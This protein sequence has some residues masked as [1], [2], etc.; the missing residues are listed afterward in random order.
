M[1][2]KQKS[3]LVVA[4][5]W[6]QDKFFET[7]YVNDINKNG[8]EEV[9]SIVMNNENGKVTLK[10]KTNTENYEFL[11]GTEDLY[12]CFEDGKPKTSKTL[13][14]SSPTTDIVFGNNKEQIEKFFEDDEEDTEEENYTKQD[15]L[16]N[17]RLVISLISDNKEV[18]S[19][20]AAHKN[21]DL[22]VMWRNNLEQD[23][24]KT[25]KTYDV[26]TVVAFIGKDGEKTCGELTLTSDDGVTV[27]CPPWTDGDKN[28]LCGGSETDRFVVFPHTKHSIT[29]MEDAIKNYTTFKKLVAGRPSQEETIEE[30]DVEE[31]LTDSIVDQL[32]KSVCEL[33]ANKDEC[34]CEQKKDVLDEIIEKSINAIDEEDEEEETLT[35]EEETETICEEVLFKKMAE[36][37]QDAG[38]T[39]INFEMD[40]DG[41]VEC[42]CRLR[43]AYPCKK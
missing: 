36:Y 25:T 19:Y 4:H 6:F 28:V 7:I 35:D 30:V 37:M 21:E 9:K 39:A 16:G 20:L 38:I 12:V 34:N 15:E 40:E 14:I 3:G 29:V 5:E 2:A 31:D 27:V 1:K 42:E 32:L 13:I 18:N 41:N 23:I 22:I 10:I 24:K 33:K 26:D 43:Y 11:S 17:E 8:I